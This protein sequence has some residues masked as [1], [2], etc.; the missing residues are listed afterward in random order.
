MFRFC[1]WVVCTV[2]AANFAGRVEGQQQTPEARAMALMGQMTAEE[3]I[4]QL[5]QLF[6][7]TKPVQGIAADT[8]SYEDRIRHGQIGSLLF[9]TDLKVIN[10]L[11]GIAV[12]ET[13]LHIPILFAFDVIH[14]FD[15]EFPVPLAMAASWDPELARAGQAVA[16]EEATHAGIR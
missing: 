11:Q 12:K 5:N 1:V 6:Y 15:T 13:R 16:A 3:K 7:F 9:V 10:R 8:T 14:G 4:G 2:F